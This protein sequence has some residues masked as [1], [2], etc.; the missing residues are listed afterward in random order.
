MSAPVRMSASILTTPANVARRARL[1]SI[2]GGAAGNVIEWYDFLAYSIFAIYFSKAFFPP[3][4]HDGAAA[5]HRRDRRRR[6][7]RPSVG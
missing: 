1:T 5:E 7:H 2:I 4:Q 6:L 3:R